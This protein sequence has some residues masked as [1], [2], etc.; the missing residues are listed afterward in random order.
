MNITLICLNQFGYADG[1]LDVVFEIAKDGALKIVSADGIDLVAEWNDANDWTDL[2]VMNAPPGAWVQILF[3][4]DLTDSSLWAP[5]GE[6]VAADEAG[7]ARFKD[8]DQPGV[9]RAY[10]AKRVW[11]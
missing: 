7:L 9:F 6:P 3:T 1:N 10:R 5:L 4:D 2:T 8:A 11:P